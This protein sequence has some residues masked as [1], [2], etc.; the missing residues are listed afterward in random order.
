MKTSLKDILRD[1]QKSFNV[2]IQAGEES[3][4]IDLASE[5]YFDENTIKEAIECQAAMVSWYSS[6]LSVAEKESRRAER[7]FE[8]WW[9]DTYNEHFSIL[10]ET[11]KKPSTTSV[12]NSVK[13]T[14]EYEIWNTRIDSCKHKA[15]VMR[16]VIDLWKEKGIMMGQYVRV[17]DLEIFVEG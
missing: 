14:K 16:A 15:S 6:L 5:L 1:R 12:E 9:A 2:E 13:R 10:S 4:T 3:V 11:G 8:I 17:L 7:R